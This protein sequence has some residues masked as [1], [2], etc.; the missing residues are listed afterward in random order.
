MQAR[1]VVRR[2]LLGPRVQ[3]EAG[4]GAASYQAQASLCEILAERS[5]SLVR[6]LDILVE[7]FSRQ[8]IR[9]VGGHVQA[10]FIFASVWG[11]THQE[12]A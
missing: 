11:H 1:A 6:S 3:S 10:G 9:V 12:E 8:D 4:A 2:A 7:F 5:L